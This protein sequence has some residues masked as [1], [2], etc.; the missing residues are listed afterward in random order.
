MSLSSG[1][2]QKLRLTGSVAARLTQQAA[3]SA[4]PGVSLT[5]SRSPIQQAALLLSIPDTKRSSWEEDWRVGDPYF[6]QPK[7]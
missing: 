2:E 5:W 4:S 1:Q 7:G 6:P 3:S